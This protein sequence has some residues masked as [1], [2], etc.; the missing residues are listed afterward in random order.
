MAEP[1][2]RM[3]E[4]ASSFGG[5]EFN[6]IEIARILIRDIARSLKRK[7]SASTGA[8]G[9]RRSRFASAAARVLRSAIAPPFDVAIYIA[10]CPRAFPP[11]KSLGSVQAALNKFHT[12]KRPRREHTRSAAIVRLS[13]KIREYESPFRPSRGVLSF[14]SGNRRQGDDFPR[15]FA[16]SSAKPGNVNRIF[17]AFEKNRRVVERNLQPSSLGIAKRSREI[18]RVRSN[19]HIYLLNTLRAHARASASSANSRSRAWQCTRH[20]RLFIIQYYAVAG[21]EGSVWRF[22]KKI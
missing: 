14:R 21:C 2:N 10:I 17:A 19:K 13:R 20:V 18:A 1:E 8:E 22:V 5:A 7:L 3:E 15:N 16:V 9:E 11:W 6:E 4:L 12:S